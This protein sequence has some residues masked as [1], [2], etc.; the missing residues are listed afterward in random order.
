[1]S[2]LIKRSDL[3]KQ[4]YDRALTDNEKTKQITTLGIIEMLYKV[5]KKESATV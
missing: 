4:D 2:T 1:M 5:Y 3:N